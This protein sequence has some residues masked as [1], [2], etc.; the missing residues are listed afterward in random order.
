MLSRIR[1]RRSCLLVLVFWLFGESA[2]AQHAIPHCKDAMARAATRPMNSDSAGLCTSADMAIT[3]ASRAVG[4]AEGVATKSQEGPRP[5]RAS[6]RV[7]G[8]CADLAPPD[9]ACV[10]C[11]YPEKN[12]IE[13][14]IPAR[15]RLGDLYLDA[16]KPEDL[17]DDLAAILEGP[18]SYLK[19]LF[20]GSWP[21]G[22]T[23]EADLVDLCW[24]YQAFWQKRSFAWAV[25]DAERNY[26]GCAYYFPIS[27]DK[28]ATPAKEAQAYAWIR[29]G[30]KDSPETRDFYADY[31]NWIHSP[32]WPKLNVQ[33][34]TPE[35]K[36]P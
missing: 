16:L 36:Q 20:G 18:G 7:P 31:R 8:V 24:H 14:D 25:R 22:L 15:V 23:R 12:F 26:L 9:W 11:E 13:Y 34:Y 28:G 21:Q 19:G 27:K 3:L 30:S 17:E 35:N 5:V 2:A 4:A 10:A 32:S 29:F 6:G 33:F 1:S